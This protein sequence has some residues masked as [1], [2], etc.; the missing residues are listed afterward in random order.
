MF[1]SLESDDEASS[2]KKVMMQSMCIYVQLIYTVTI[3]TQS[4]GNKGN[5]ML[6]LFLSISSNSPYSR[7]L[8]FLVGAAQLSGALNFALNSNNI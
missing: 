3:L 5:Y 6:I 8:F 1:D 7:S 2:K 4:K